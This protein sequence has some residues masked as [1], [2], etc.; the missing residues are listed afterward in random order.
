MRNTIIISV[1]FLFLSCRNKVEEIGKPDPYILT[2]NHIS[3]DCGAYQMRFKDGKYIFNFALSGTCKKIKAEDYIK[4]YSRYLNFYNDSLVNRRGYILLQYY[5]IHTNIKDFQ[6]SIINIT[7]RNLK[8]H[9]SLV[10]F[11]DKQFTIKV[12]DIPL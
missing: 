4:E 3:E 10:E 7:K 8:T 12:G 5:G 6:Y 9:V 11:D 1:L 2:E